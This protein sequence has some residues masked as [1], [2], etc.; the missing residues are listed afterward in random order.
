MTVIIIIIIIIIMGN[1]IICTINC[2][3]TIAATLY[4]R[5]TWFVAGIQG[6]S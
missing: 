2:N 6:V 4:T 3:H 5:E 1:S